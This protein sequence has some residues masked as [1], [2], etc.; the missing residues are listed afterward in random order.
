MRLL[1]MSM[2]R[3]TVVFDL[4]TSGHGVLFLANYWQAECPSRRQEV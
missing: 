1:E 3:T 2:C 4:C